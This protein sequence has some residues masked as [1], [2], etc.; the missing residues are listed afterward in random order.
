MFEAK[1]G[2]DKILF[3][4]MNSQSYHYQTNYN[5]CKKINI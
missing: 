5:R 3:N 2:S 1:K 4:N